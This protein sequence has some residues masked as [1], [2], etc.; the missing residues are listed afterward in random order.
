MSASLEMPIDVKKKLMDLA[1]QLPRDR[2]AVFLK[3]VTN[4]IADLAAD[5][6]TPIVYAAVGWIIGQL[7]ESILT[8]HIPLS[9]IVV[10][11]ASD[12][13]SEW[14]A[15]LGFGAGAIQEVRNSPERTAIAKIVQKEIRRAMEPA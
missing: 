8:F 14:L 6:P 7:L 15:A 9:D 2:R 10:Q 1:E 13:L 4:S 11:L 3:N 12:R 5:H